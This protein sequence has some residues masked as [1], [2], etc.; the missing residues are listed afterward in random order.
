MPEVIEAGQ[1]AFKEEDPRPQFC[2]VQQNAPIADARERRQIA[3]HA[4]RFAYLR[5]KLRPLTM[6][7][8]TQGLVK[9]T[10]LPITRASA[11]PASGT[12]GPG[13]S[14]SRGQVARAAASPSLRG[15]FQSSPTLVT[16]RNERQVRPHR[17]PSSASRK[18]VIQQVS[19]TPSK[20]S[21]QI[22]STDISSPSPSPFLT[23]DV[24]P[25][26]TLP[27]SCRTPY[28]KQLVKYCARPVV[29][30]CLGADSVQC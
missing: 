11:L 13:R 10:P 24:D 19:H 3:S 14:K 26:Q 9:P 5:R 6:R 2:W 8:P 30:T 18:D 21:L 27:S 7:D 16:Y 23:H 4:A 29:L 20:E 17:F 25:F 22:T 12:H 15:R 28:E 1:T